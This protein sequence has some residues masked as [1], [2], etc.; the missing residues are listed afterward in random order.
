MMMKSK[1]PVD[2]KVVF[3][4][5]GLST[6]K[7]CDVI[8]RVALMFECSRGRLFGLSVG[9]EIIYV[10]VSFNRAYCGEALRRCEA[11]CAYS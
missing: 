5:G 2:V 1:P 10:L 3:Q 8:R 4:N 6:G 11:C 7:R 9:V